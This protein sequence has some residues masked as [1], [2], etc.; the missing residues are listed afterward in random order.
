MWK[1]RTSKQHHGALSESAGSTSSRELRSFLQASGMWFVSTSE[2]TPLFCCQ[3]SSFFRFLRWLPD[4]SLLWTLLLTQRMCAPFS[5]EAIRCRYLTLEQPMTQQ[6]LLQSCSSF[7]SGLP[8]FQTFSKLGLLYITHIK[9]TKPVENRVCCLF[10]SSNFCFGSYKYPP[11]IVHP[12]IWFSEI[13]GF[14]TTCHA[15]WSCPL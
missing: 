1:D 9:Y 7:T 13:I 3:T 2:I 4:T 8:T 6:H 10:Y 15:N 14:S 5:E 11:K 12:Q